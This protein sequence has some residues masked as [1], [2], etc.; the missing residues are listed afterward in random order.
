MA[1][2]I[3]KKAEGLL[4]E[5]VGRTKDAA[6]GLTGDMG[7]Q[8]GGKK[9]QLSGKAQQEFADLYD[10]NESKLEAATSFIQDHPVMALLIATVLG[11]VIGRV[12]FKK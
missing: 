6:G 1:E 5:A 10:A 12:F 4:D 8:L 2:S 3:G 7:M 11:L 9:D